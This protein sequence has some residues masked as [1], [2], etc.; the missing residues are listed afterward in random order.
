MLQP[1]NACSG[2][3]AEA[4]ESWRDFGPV[5][6]EYTVGDPVLKVEGEGLAFEVVL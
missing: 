1:Q 5:S 3:K 6:L 4:G 2:R